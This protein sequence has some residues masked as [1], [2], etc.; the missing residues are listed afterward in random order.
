M[1]F[2]DIA[3]IKVKAGNGGNGIV[4]FRKELYV[5]KGGP[6]GGDGGKGGNIVFIGSSSI[7]TLIELSFNKLIKA[8][9]GKNGQSKNMH[10]KNGS[11]KIIKVPI[12]T[13]LINK[14]DN[15]L[16]FDINKAGQKIIVAKGGIGGR[17]NARFASSINQAPTIFEQGN[18]GEN[19]EIICELKL[20]ADVGFVGLPN[21]GKSTLLSVLTKAKPVIKDYE[22]T[23]INPQLGVCSVNKTNSFVIADLP[24]LIKGASLGKGLG[25]FFLKHIERCSVIV[26]V[27]DASL[28][29][30]QII[31]NYNIIFNELKSYNFK[32]LQKQQ[33]IILNKIDKISD[34]KIINNFKKYLLKNNI[35][36]ELVPVSSLKKINLEIL[37]FKIND[38][39]K[40]SN[41]SNSL[42]IIEE[43]FNINNKSKHKVYKF[44]QDFKTKFIIN[45]LG[46]GRWE[47]KGNAVFEI[48]HRFPT[49]TVD[50]LLKFNQELIK[51]GVFKELRKKGAKN[52][53][54]IK[55]FKIEMEWKD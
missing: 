39:I 15:S 46:N 27:I 47:I 9:D 22:F 43:E 28:S 19:K 45:N 1:K 23:T 37:K 13:I 12:G 21:V 51:L 3:Y 38:L 2:I 52:G 42:S 32:L 53:D 8:E 14:K 25:Y 24:G 40:N 34:E 44:K 31:K 5:P 33:L 30:K 29:L 26:H 49:I 54:T 36:I 50:N 11:D 20:L 48:Y 17:G 41:I 55:I 10:G 4:A 7:R 18:L 35:K 16:I 6:S